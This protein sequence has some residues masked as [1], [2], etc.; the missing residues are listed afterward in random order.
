MRRSIIF[1][2]MMAMVLP[3][4]GQGQFSLDGQ[5]RPRAE[6]RNGYREMPTEEAKPAGQVNQRTRLSL[7]YTF[8][9]RV[10]TRISLQDL[11]IW[12]QNVTMS[13][14]PTFSIYEAWVALMPG[15]RFSITAGRQELRYDTQRLMAINDW[16]LTG[17]TH[18]ALVARYETTGG[19]RLHIGAAFNQSQNLNFG[20]HYPLNNYKTLN[21]IWYHTPLSDNL[22]A[23]FHFIADGYEHP[24][25]P[26]DLNLRATWAS[27]LVY[28]PGAFELRLYPSF[29]HGKTAMGQDISAWYL[30]VEGFSRINEN[31][32]VRPG[33]EIFSGNDQV[34]PGEKFNA[35]SDL[36]GM[37]H[38]RNG[39][40]DY[41]TTFPQHTNNAGLINPYVKN[42]F[43]LS[44]NTNFQADLHLFFMQNDF[45]DPEDTN[46]AIDKYLGT[47]IDLTLNYRFNPFT[48]IIFGYSVMFGSESMEILKGG[49]KDEFAHWAF[50]MI[51]MTP[52]FI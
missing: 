32:T 18:D 12:G 33:V 36:Y 42:V 25:D 41:F 47:E 3:L 45:P 15:E 38:A 34:N 52:R 8:D 27:Y 30:M 19:S 26:E 2:L 29:Q 17:R 48:R 11:R 31:W 21:Y 5:I 1:L 10:A 28:S 6:F 14:N 13:N 50:V 40:M 37:G 24:D 4:L 43:S 9:E 22:K 16:A 35:F 23:S 44:E 51:R 49:S 46:T 20:T 7:S 39:F